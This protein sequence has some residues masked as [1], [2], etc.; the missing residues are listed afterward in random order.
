MTKK[1]KPTNYSKWKK[2]ANPASRTARALQKYRR[3]A[4]LSQRQLGKLAKFSQG[5]LGMIE[6][7]L[8]QPRPKTM[9]PIIKALN[10]LGVKCDHADFGLEAP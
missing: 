9:T 10:K 8:C 7:G 1:K 6:R 2:N 5:Y 4:K 3:T